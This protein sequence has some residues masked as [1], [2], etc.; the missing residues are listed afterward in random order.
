MISLT[1]VGLEIVVDFDVLD[2]ESALR[3]KRRK[4]GLVE[5]AEGTM[6]ASY[7][8]LG[9]LT[10]NCDSIEYLPSVESGAIDGYCEHVEWGD[11]DNVL[12]RMEEVPGYP[13]SYPSIC[14]RSGSRGTVCRGS[15]IIFLVYLHSNH[16]TALLLEAF[17]TPVGLQCLP[18]RL[19][20][21]VRLSKSTSRHLCTVCC[22][23]GD[24]SDKV[25]HSVTLTPLKVF[26]FTL[27]TMT[28]WCLPT[29]TSL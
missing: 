9:W 11:S 12:L 14:K 22:T 6:L 8:R 15:S 3:R 10:R 23:L 17:F 13:K 18:S 5:R 2:L 16:V 1:F 20:R 25:D 24:I 19:L 28:I 26:N 29:I 21:I 7:G 4:E 27:E